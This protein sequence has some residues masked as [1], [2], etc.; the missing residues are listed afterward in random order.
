MNNELKVIGFWVIC[1]T[2]SLNVYGIE[3]EKMLVGINDNKP[4]WHK[5]Y[6]NSK[7][8]F[9][10]FGGATWDLSECIRIYN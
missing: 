10:K 9:I 7:R 8:S 4:R 1:N 5:I 2:A 6:T 3:D